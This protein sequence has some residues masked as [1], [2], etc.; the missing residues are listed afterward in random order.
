MTDR[1]PLQPLRTAP[2][3][4]QVVHELKRLIADGTLKPGDQLP[5]ERDLSERLGVSRSTVRE[6]VQLL[7][8]LGMLDVRHGHGT[9]VRA[10]AGDDELLRNTW[11]DWTV[12][13]SDRIREL[14]E[15]RRG[16]DGLAAELAALRRDDEALATMAEAIEQMREA[17]ATHDVPTLVEADLAFH[18][19]LFAASGNV[20][21][22]ELG[23]ALGKRLVRERAAGWDLEG[24][25][26]RSLDEHDAILDA[27]RA[28][29]PNLARAAVIDHLLSVERDIELLLVRLADEEG[30]APEDG[31][32]S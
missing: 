17:D 20:A 32:R 25:P 23:D 31:R 18:R 27:V 24:R 1:I 8:A 30:A 4:E 16:I 9:F 2:L 12:D 3:K 6:A 10:D 21:L 5:G 7:G 11:R 15:V 29:D 14:L 19:A 26:E 28:G 22:H 13:N